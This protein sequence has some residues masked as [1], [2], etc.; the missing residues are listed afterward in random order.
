MFLTVS[1]SNLRGLVSLIVFA[2]IVHPKIKIWP[3]K[4]VSS[5]LDF[6]KYSLVKIVHFSIIGKIAAGT[7][8]YRFPFVFHALKKESHTSL[9]NLSYLVAFSPQKSS[10]KALVFAGVYGTQPQFSYVKGEVFIW[11]CNSQIQKSGWLLTKNVWQHVCTNWKDTA[12][13]VSVAPLAILAKFWVLV[14]RK[15]ECSDAMCTTK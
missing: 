8:C 9:W 7:L 10:V 1:K 4:V 11:C 12:S 15:S 2:G 3:F 5:R 6:S 13:W 14:G